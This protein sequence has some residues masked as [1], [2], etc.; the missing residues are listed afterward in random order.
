MCAF[1]I[2]FKKLTKASLQH[3]LYSQQLRVP[4]AES[5]AERSHTSVLIHV[6]TGTRAATSLQS[7]S[8]VRHQPRLHPR[9]LRMTPLMQKRPL[10]IHTPVCKIKY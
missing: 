1:K 2:T 5:R 10:Q 7:A 3:H 8:Q 4:G 9:A 6:L